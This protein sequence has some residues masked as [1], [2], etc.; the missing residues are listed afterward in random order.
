MKITIGIP[1]HNACNAV[2]MCI[3]KACSA[4]FQNNYDFQ[5]IVI[6]DHSDEET[7]QMLSAL[8]AD[9][10]GNVKV[11]HTE[12]YINN[13]NPNLGWNMNFLFQ[14]I[15]PDDDYYLNLESDVIILTHTIN[16]LV[17]A[18]ESHRDQGFAAVPMLL[19]ADT[20]RINWAIGH[21]RRTYQELLIPVR[22]IPAIKLMDIP[23]DAP[24][25]FMGNIP[26]CCTLFPAELLRN[27]FTKINDNLKLWCCDDDLYKRMTLHTKN[28]V[29]FCKKAIAIHLNA[30][31][32]QQ[33]Y[34]H[35]VL[36]ACHANNE[37]WRTIMNVRQQQIKITVGM[38]IHNALHVIKK[39]IPALIHCLNY[40]GINFQLIII[41][42]NSDSETKEYL[43]SLNGDNVKVFHTEDFISEAN[44]NLSWNVNFL[45]DQVREDDDYY[46]NLESDVIVNEDTVPLLIGGLQGFKNAIAA[47]PILATEKKDIN[48]PVSPFDP[49]VTHTYI[50]MREPPTFSC[51]LIRGEIARDRE[52]RADINI[53][54]WYADV[55]FNRHLIFKTDRPMLLV[56]Q[57]HALHYQ[58]SSSMGIFYQFPNVPT[59]E[60]TRAY[61]KN[62][63]KLLIDATVAPEYREY[64]Y[65]SLGLK[66]N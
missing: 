25:D 51:L 55:D 1:V 39:S 41:D 5:I 18:L 57:S 16:N 32:R 6:D 59:L 40:H 11:Y 64:Y 47:H 44:P 36:S 10:N 65:V 35:L 48:Y 56:H 62:K 19:E 20:H 30:Q 17:F 2:K 8:E 43:R 21:W 60:E 33:N 52:L 42:D 12:D 50:Y 24:N 14:Q 53:K 13:K 49:S 26:V 7:K 28:D 27:K 46:L 9:C 66:N 37:N 38:P 58:N 54:L 22:E 45:L 29:I 63:W 3:E 15:R 4:C 61:L 23:I 34:D 31:S